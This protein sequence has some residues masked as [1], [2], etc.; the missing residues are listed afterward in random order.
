MT[1]YIWHDGGRCDNSTDDIEEAR[2]IK[3]WLAERY[4]D[5][6]IADADGNVIE[7]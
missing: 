6:Y 1:Y 3:D 5:V 4:T 7:D 2:R